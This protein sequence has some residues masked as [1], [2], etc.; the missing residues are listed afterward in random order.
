MRNV[1]NTK[2]S[3][4]STQSSVPSSGFEEDPI[5]SIDGALTLNWRYDGDDGTRIA[6]SE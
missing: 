4:D 3:E 5:M 2:I 6:L 1:L